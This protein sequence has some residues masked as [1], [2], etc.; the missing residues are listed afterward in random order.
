MSATPKTV[1]VNGKRFQLQPLPVLKAASLNAR[2]TAIFGPLLFG[3]I[4][5]VSQ[6]LLAYPDDEQEKLIQTLLSTVTYLPTAGAAV[7][8]A[9]EA[10]IGAAFACDLSSVYSLAWEILEYNGFPFV[11]ALKE[12]GGRFADLV[13]SLQEKALSSVKA[14]ATGSETTETD[15]T[16]PPLSEEA[17]TALNSALSGASL[18]SLKSS[19]PSGV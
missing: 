5:D 1:T 4:P 9:D 18:Q 15:G 13:K 19:I 3:R 17:R 12:A 7:S 6:A 16:E 10:G 11:A 2:L 14:G 8:L